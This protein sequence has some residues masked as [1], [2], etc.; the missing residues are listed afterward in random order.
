MS[1]FI[2]K[3]QESRRKRKGICLRMRTG[4]NEDVMKAIKKSKLKRPSKAI[5]T[6]EI[7]ELRKDGEVLLEVTCNSLIDML[8]RKLRYNVFHILIDENP[9]WI[10][11]GDIGRGLS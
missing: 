3:D 9:E 8:R 4:V 7:H 11:E 5:L 10:C 2:L 6:V 1:W